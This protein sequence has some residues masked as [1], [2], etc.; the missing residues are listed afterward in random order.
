MVITALSTQG[1]QLKTEEGNKPSVCPEVPV[2][3]TLEMSPYKLLSGTAKVRS[4]VLK[5]CKTEQSIETQ[6]QHCINAGGLEKSFQRDTSRAKLGPGL[7]DRVQI[8]E[9][10]NSSL[11]TC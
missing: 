3:L 10:M 11:A 7:P 4:Q 8:S 5:G 6:A 1:A 2:C 9:N